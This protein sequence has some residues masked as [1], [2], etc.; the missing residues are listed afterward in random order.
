MSLLRPVFRSWAGR[1]GAVA[2][3]LAV[4]LS[5]APLADADAPSKSAAE[6]TAAPSLLLDVPVD[7]RISDGAYAG[8]QF[9]GDPEGGPVVTARGASLAATLESVAPPGTVEKPGAGA[10][11]G[12]GVFFEVTDAD[13]EPVLRRHTRSQSGHTAV[14]SLPP[15]GLADGAYRWRVRVRDGATASRWT[16]WCDF[17]VRLTDESGDDRAGTGP[18]R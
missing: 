10:S 11:P 6:A 9:C 17:T 4:G 12:R 3:A 1:A 14:L 8:F 16:E 5:L 2:A 18:S 15:R 7:P 13:G